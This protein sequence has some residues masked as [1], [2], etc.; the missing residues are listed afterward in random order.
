MKLI[1]TA[2]GEI[3]ADVITNRAMSIDDILSLM[4]YT[5]DNDNGELI[6]EQHEHTNIYYENLFLEI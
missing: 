5:I 6:N 1:D 4:R 2:T 3:V